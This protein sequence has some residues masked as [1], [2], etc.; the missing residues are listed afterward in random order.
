LFL[1]A[2]SG[3]LILDAQVS[4]VK[5]IVRDRLANNYNNAGAYQGDVYA[6]NQSGGCDG[7][8]ADATNPAI[9]PHCLSSRSPM[10]AGA[11]E[12]HPEPVVKLK[13]LA[14]RLDDG[15]HRLLQFV[16]HQ[17]YF[18]GCAAAHPAFRAGANGSNQQI[19]IIRKPP[20][21]EAA[22]SS[23]GASREY[24][25]A[26]I[27][28]MLASNPND[29]HPERPGF[30]PEDIDLTAGGCVIGPAIA[31]KGVGGA[32]LGSTRIALAAAAQGDASWN[33]TLAPTGS[34]C[35]AGNP[36][37]LVDGWCGWN[38]RTPRRMDRNYYRVV[39][40]GLRSRRQ[41]SHYPGRGAGANPVH[42]NAILILQKRADRDA[43]G[44]I[45]PAAGSLDNPKNIFE[46]TGGPIQLVSD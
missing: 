35:A 19:A 13:R 2:N 20:L 38:T 4:A 21:G 25:K 30:L 5:E 9:D 8:V 26:N 11:A 43:N 17:W 16:R 44:V 14:Q 12:S 33:A 37:N 32:A 36:W 7:T 24:N 3:P 27:R 1:A 34:P 10:P 18:E 46:A 40:I 45:D 6:P 28:V 15:F 23:T 42:P 29:L 41:S 39:A 22:T 31:V